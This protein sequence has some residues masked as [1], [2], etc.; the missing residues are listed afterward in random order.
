M[1]N[2][3]QPWS[4]VGRRLGAES[5]IMRLMDDLGR[6]MAGQDKVLMLGGGNPAHVPGVQAV[7]RMAEV[8]ADGGALERM[9]TNYDTPRGDPRFI[10]AFAAF[11]N[12]QFNLGIRPANVAITNGGQ[13]A[14]FCLLNLFGGLSE[15]GEL[16]RILFP[17]MPEYIGYADQCLTPDSYRA[18]TPRI[19]PRGAHRFKYRIDFD[20]LEVG[21]DIAAICLSRPTNPTGN[22]VTDDEVRQLHALARARGIP[23]IIDNAYGVPFPGIVFAAA[24]PVWLEGSILTFS[25][26]KLG[27]PG[28][29]TGIVVGPE[30]V[31]E[32]LVAMNG[33]MSLANG[34]IGQVLVRPL[35]EDDVILALA[36]ETIRPYYEAKAR[37]AL[38]WTEA[39]F[40]DGLDYQVHCCEGA[41]F[42]WFWFR[43]LPI[44]DIELYERL[45][46]R[47]VLVVPGSYFF[48]GEGAC[49]PQRH[50]CIRVN[51]TQSEATVREGLA[52]IADEVAKA[53]RAG[54]HA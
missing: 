51:Y 42:L 10:E 21:S 38:E 12:R 6:A 25:L 5:G 44:T 52:I 17:L 34:N 23:L 27:L 13:S 14:F 30:P 40:E 29:R 47:G 45:K 43:G 26:S 31:I 1:N 46:R 53:Y 3:E 18:G 54:R 35:L 4:A 22:V 37:Q 24:E 50:E 8:M 15:S 33:V 49:G 48:F 41:L 20:R 36:R 28:T 19:E 9:L 7:W 16:R 32:A 2:A 11:M 39:C